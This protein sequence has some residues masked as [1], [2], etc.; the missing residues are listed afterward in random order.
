ML[1][2]QILK[3]MFSSENL[4]ELCYSENIVFV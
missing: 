3:K 1:V 2:P 4:L